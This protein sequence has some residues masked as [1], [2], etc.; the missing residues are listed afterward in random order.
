MT[1]ITQKD[2]TPLH[3]RKFAET[4]EGTPAHSTIPMAWGALGATDTSPSAIT[5]PSSFSSISTAWQ[6]SP[7]MKT[8]IR[9]SAN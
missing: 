9:S 5:Q 3:A 4:Y 1:T 2:P 8:P 6:K 7:Q